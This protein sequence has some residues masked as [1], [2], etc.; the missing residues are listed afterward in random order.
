MPQKKKVKTIKE[1]KKQKGLWLFEVQDTLDKL[2]ED[3][4]IKIYDGKKEFLI[5]RMK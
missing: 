5:I 3:K 2:K 4:M 1:G